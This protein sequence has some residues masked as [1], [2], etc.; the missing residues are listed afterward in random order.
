MANYQIKRIG[1]PSIQRD[2]RA[3]SLVMESQDGNDITLKILSS[4][5]KVIVERLL[6]AIDAVDVTQTLWEGKEEEGNEVKASPMV[7]QAVGV[8]FVSEPKTDFRYIVVQTPKGEEVL[9]GLQPSQVHSLMAQMQE[10]LSI[11]TD[12]LDGPAN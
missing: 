5:L 8:G 7:Y 2:G 12:P 1:V 11:Q 6:D 10:I 4:D 9:I 3:V